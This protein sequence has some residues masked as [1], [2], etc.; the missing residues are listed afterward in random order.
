MRGWHQVFSYLT[1]DEQ[2]L[3]VDFSEGEIM[4][5]VTPQR[6]GIKVPHNSLGDVQTD[7]TANGLQIERL[8]DPS[9]RADDIHANKS[10]QHRVAT[11]KV[12]RLRMDTLDG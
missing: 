6:T 4:I 3:T 7:N 11:E 10:Y 8:N 12:E 1:E 9:V 5:R 2:A